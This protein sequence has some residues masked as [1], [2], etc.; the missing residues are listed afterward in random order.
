MRG[1]LEKMLPFP[2]LGKGDLRLS[3][4]FCVS[5]QTHDDGF[6]H[7]AAKG[8]EELEDRGV[9]KQEA[10][11]RGQIPRWCKSGEAFQVLPVTEYICRVWL[12]TVLPR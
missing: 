9:G 3:W 2:S 10:A 8:E 1:M 7:H 4:S 5:S 11:E 12:A 6:S